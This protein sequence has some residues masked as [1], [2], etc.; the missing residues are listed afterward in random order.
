MAW[1]SPLEP[2]FCRNLGGWLLQG[3]FA[4][5]AATP[6]CLLLTV[7]QIP[8]PVVC[9][10]C[11]KTKFQNYFFHG[12]I[13]QTNSARLL[14]CLLAIPI[15]GFTVHQISETSILR[16]KKPMIARSGY[17]VYVC[18]YGCVG[19][20]VEEQQKANCMCLGGP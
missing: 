11:A 6:C 12:H 5:K 15:L 13:K 8:T 2:P 1:N 7:P 9:F 3:G 4:H 18:V 14:G 10:T 17:M 19:G 16:I 20:C